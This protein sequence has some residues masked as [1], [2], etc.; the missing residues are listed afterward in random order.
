MRGCSRSPTPKKVSISKQISVVPGV[1]TTVRGKA[2]LREDAERAVVTSLS[3]AE[4]KQLLEGP[5]GRPLARIPH[6]WT[7]LEVVR[8]PARWKIRYDKLVFHVD[9]ATGKVTH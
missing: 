3:A 6:G 8:E 9:A 7:D 2:A 5:L 1:T 4:R